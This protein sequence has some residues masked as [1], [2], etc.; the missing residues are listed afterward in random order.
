MP[1]PLVI[2]VPHAG[3]RAPP[4]V[5]RLNVLTPEQIARDG[6]EGAA[7]IYD[8]ASE[9]LS[10]HAAPIARAFVDLNRAEDDIR[11][12]GVIKTH[13][14]W[15]E[16]IYRKPPGAAL[17]RVLLNRY[18]RPYHTRLSDAP[19]GAVLGID[20]HTMAAQGPPVGPH[21]GRPRPQVCLSNAD[22]ACLDSML[23]SMAKCFA[24]EFDEVTL[25][26][27]FKGGHII[28]RHAAKRPWIQ[29]ELSRAPFATDTEKRARVLAALRRWC[30]KD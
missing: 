19:P 7:V 20:C 4:E 1:L 11:K 5:E 9:V 8:F 23:E 29:L 14:I 27:P 30:G 22:G 26:A 24:A 28:R 17:V 25:N 2:S 21:P 18:H 16:P 12:D 10:F 15:D 3:L 6:D 13:T